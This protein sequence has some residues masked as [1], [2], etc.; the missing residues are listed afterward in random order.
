MKFSIHLSMLCRKWTDDISIYLDDIKKMGYD[1][2]EL[3][4]FGTDKNSIKENAEK[5]KMNALDL[6]C[7]TGL[8][9]NQDLSSE[10]KIK[11]ENGIDYLKDSVE[12]VSQCGG[13]ILNGVL[14][15]P[16]QG[17]SKENK[18]DRWKRAADSFHQLED[19]LNKNNVRLNLEVLN[20][21]ES[22]FF[23]TLEEGAEFIEMVNSENIKLLADTFHMNIEESD[24]FTNIN[25][26]FDSIGIFHISENHRGV[27]ST[28]HINWYEFLKTLYRK[29]YAGYLTLESF[30][31]QG[32]DVGNA[33]FIWRNLGKNPLKEAERNIKFLK[34]ILKDV[35]T[36]DKL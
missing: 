21:F 7:G 12:L 22:D 16:W 19:I 32:T 10:D 2:V 23:N 24:M 5:I 15:A 9:E 6:T 35:T 30:I 17:F 4:L 14:Y 13:K 27:P 26:Y 36:D 31:E 28:G 29:K 1:A 3:S 33:L 34:N 8:G 20:R 25:K 11:R 18:K